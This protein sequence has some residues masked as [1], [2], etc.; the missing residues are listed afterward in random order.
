MA[1][2]GSV[3]SGL[4]VASIVAQ[5]VSSDRAAPDARFD[6][7][8]RQINAQVSAIGTLRGAFSALRTALTSLASGDSAR[9]RKA[10]VPEGAHFTASAAPG[11]AVGQYAI[12]VRS[13]AVA[14]KL[15]SAPFLNLL[16]IGNQSDVL[17]ALLG[18]HNS[19]FCAPP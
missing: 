7:T 13:L 3:G 1:G 14:H 18:L 11:A 5:L 16:F 12:E 8:E 15:G 2:I 19:R 10:S 4:D 17:P 6:R 9:A